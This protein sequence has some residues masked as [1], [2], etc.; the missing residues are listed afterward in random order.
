[1]NFY[2]ALNLALIIAFTSILLVIAS[3]GGC[4]RKRIYCYE[5]DSRYDS[6]CG[7]AFNLTR[8]TGLIVP[9]YDYCVKLKHM[10]DNQFHY[11]RTCA[12]S[13]KGIYIKKTEVCYSTKTQEKG[14]LCFCEQ[15]LC[16]IAAG[17]SKKL[18]DNIKQ[19]LV[20][21]IFIYFKFLLY[22]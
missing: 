4:C 19:I 8:D 3:E 18:I 22:S 7:D 2:L 1:M 13:L 14:S 12:D 17:P 21:F 16:N 15:D 9:C 10:I 6:R 20:F 5:C 11:L